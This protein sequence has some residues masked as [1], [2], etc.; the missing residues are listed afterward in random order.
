MAAADRQADVDRQ[1]HALAHRLGHVEAG[2][3]QCEQDEPR[4]RLVQQHE[5]EAA[6]D[7]RHMQD[8]DAWVRRA[9]QRQRVGVARLAADH[10]QRQLNELPQHDGGE[11]R[12]ESGLRL[13]QRLCRVSQRER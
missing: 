13:D 12:G 1:A 5:Q 11:P 4:Q 8:D 7:N 6:E 3:D 10:E 9:H 2:L